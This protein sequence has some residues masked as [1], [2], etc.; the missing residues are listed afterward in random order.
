MKKPINHIPSHHHL[1]VLVEAFWGLYQTFGKIKS[2]CPGERE[3]IRTNEVAA[4][5]I[6]AQPKVGHGRVLTGVEGEIAAAVMEAAVGAVNSHP[7]LARDSHSL[8]K[9]GHDLSCCI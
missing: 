2:P 1:M 9:T 6:L 7:S 5:T 8:I 3:N 4:I